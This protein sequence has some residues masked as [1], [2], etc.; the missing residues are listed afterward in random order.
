MFLSPLVARQAYRLF[1][2]SILL[3]TCLYAIGF[4]ALSPLDRVDPKD[5]AAASAYIRKN[6]QA[7]DVLAWRPVWAQEVRE[8]L[9]DLRFLQVRDLDAEVTALTLMAAPPRASPSSLVTPSSVGSGSG[10]GCQR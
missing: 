10:C 2:L 9:G 7:D 1:P 4:W 6:W 8:Q 5:L 3:A